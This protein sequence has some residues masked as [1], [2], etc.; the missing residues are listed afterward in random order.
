M[1]R[2]MV[3]NGAGVAQ[4][5][6]AGLLALVGV[7]FGVSGVLFAVRA[8]SPTLDSAARQPLPPPTA[9]AS[10][11]PPVAPP[12]PGPVAKEGASLRLPLVVTAGP[13]RSE[14]RVDGVRLG[15]TPYVGEVTCRAGETVKIDLLPPKG[16][17]QSWERRCAPG[18]LRVGE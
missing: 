2:Q 16:V 4:L 15:H 8:E 10:E 1:I 17:P 18:T 5:I 14:L 13:D 7:R 12:P 11:A 3:I 6:A 9:T